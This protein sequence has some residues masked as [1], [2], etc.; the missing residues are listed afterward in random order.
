MDFLKQDKKDLK[1]IDSLEDLILD[2]M[3]D[4]INLSDDAKERLQA[5]GV[6]ICETARRLHREILL[7]EEIQCDYIKN[8]EKIL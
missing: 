1:K 3:W 5:E 4:A 6:N 7:A 8:A 2:L